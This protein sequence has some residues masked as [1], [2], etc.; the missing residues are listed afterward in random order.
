MV[1]GGQGFI[2]SW[3]AERLLG[4][5]REVVVP[6]R[7]VHTGLRF[8]EEDVASRCT[9]ARADI[10]DHERMVATL[11]EHRVE[12]VFHLAA[13]PIVGIANRSPLSTWESNVTA[14]AGLL[15]ACRSAMNAGALERVVVASSDHCYGAHAE[16]PFREDHPM[17]PTFPYDV[18]KGCADMIARCYAV[19]YDLPVAVTRLANVYGGGDRNWS[20]I[21]PDSARAL[22]RGERPVIRSD[23]SP[24]R[25]YLYVE[26]AVD[27]YLTVADSLNSPQHYGRA[28]N[29]GMGEPVSVLDLVRQLIAVSGK[30]LEPDVRGKGKPRAEADRLQVD[31]TAIQ[32]ELGW[33]PRWSLEEGLAKTY[34]WYEARLGANEP[35]TVE[36]AG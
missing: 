20:R 31:S 17:D 10:R 29:A 30:Q 36:A 6:C 27:V 33:T 18:S 2:G 24:E 25:E 12:A 8:Y 1:T 35:A 13:Q 23:G 28:W 4:V 32:R 26:D 3:L 15:E 34:A 21:V 19:T 11:A 9:L 14:T 22:V 5:A 16:A 7:D